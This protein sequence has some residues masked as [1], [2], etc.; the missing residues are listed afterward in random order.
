MFSFTTKRIAASAVTGALYAVLTLVLAPIS[1]GPLQFRVS[2]VLCIMPFLIPE[3]ALGLFVGCILANIY[4]GN[5][6]DII[7][8]S[9]AT[10][11]AAVLSAKAKKEWTAC[12][13]PVVSNSLIVGAVLSFAYGIGVYPLCILQIALSEAAVMFLIGYPALKYLEKKDISSWL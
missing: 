7:F 13:W 9:L 8:G 10:L 5:V 3:S 11:I 2:E 12:L 1:Y 4:T 6:F